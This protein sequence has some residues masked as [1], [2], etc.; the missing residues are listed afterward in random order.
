MSGIYGVIHMVIV[1]VEGEEQNSRIAFFQEVSIMWFLNLEKN[2][3]KLVGYSEDPL[4][5]LMKLYPLGSLDN[6]LYKP[7]EKPSAAVNY[8]SLLIIQFACD[9]AR[10]LQAIHN[11]G[12]VHSDM[13]VVEPLLRRSSSH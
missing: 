5:I 1:I 6:L 8:S 13:K 7:Q 9:I 3:A 10:G 2:I 12:F 4:A 11:A